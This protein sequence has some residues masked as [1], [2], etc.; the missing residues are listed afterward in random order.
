MVE[1]GPVNAWGVLDRYGLPT[2]VTA[3][4]AYVVYKLVWPLL[5]K[6]IEG[7]QAVLLE[8]LKEAQSRL[9]SSQ[10]KFLQALERHDE[11]I[12]HEFGRI[13][14]RLDRK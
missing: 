14:D 13:H 12:K 7:T 2:L 6:Q 5:I 8:Q 10:E 4:L 11:I 9:D 1:S 3:G